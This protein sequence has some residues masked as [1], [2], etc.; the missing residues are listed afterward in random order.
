MATFV[1]YGVNEIPATGAQSN[2]FPKNFDSQD[3]AEIAGMEF[4]RENP[5]VPQ[6]VIFEL[7][8]RNGQ[9]VED[10]T[11]RYISRSEIA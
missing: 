5:E 4:L 10:Q 1:E 11:L 9:I 6:V 3:E 2:P 8:I 7:T